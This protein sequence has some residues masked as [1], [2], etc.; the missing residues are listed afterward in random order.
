MLM[1][2]IMIE[3]VRGEDNYESNADDDG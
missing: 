1:M 3:V 2:I